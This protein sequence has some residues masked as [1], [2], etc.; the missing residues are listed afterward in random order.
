MIEIKVTA[1]TVDDAIKQIAGFAVSAEQA[2]VPANAVTNT[3]VI[4]DAPTVVPVDRKKIE[5]NTIDANDITAEPTK[6]ELTKE[7]PKSADVEINEVDIPDVVVLR[8]AAKAK[9]EISA[10]NKVAVKEL[11]KIYDSKAIS[12]LPKNKRQAFLEDV[13]A[14]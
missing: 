10:E 12:A 6:E 9:C 1:D 4:P 13:K 11:L 5:E 8:A 14:I 7:E 3:N 2:G